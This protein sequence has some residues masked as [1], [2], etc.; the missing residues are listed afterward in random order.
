[1]L[2]SAARAHSVFSGTASGFARHGHALMVVTP[3][4][5]EVIGPTDAVRDGVRR[6]A[7]G[8]GHPPG[9]RSPQVRREQRNPSTAIADLGDDFVSGF[10]VMSHVTR[11]EPGRAS[12][13]HGCLNGATALRR[14]RQR[15][16]HQ[17]RP[18]PGCGA[19]LP[20][21]VPRSVRRAPA[22]CVGFH[23]N[24]TGICPLGRSD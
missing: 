16:A 7:R 11:R 17:Y 14:R 21:S 20:A 1:M 6:P 5:D 23:R 10:L 12:E 4:P 13:G 3:P 24:I 19:N 22:N 18:G 9:T 15:P 8:R 2:R